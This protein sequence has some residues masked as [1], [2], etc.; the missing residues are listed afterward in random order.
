ML[1]CTLFFVKLL[2]SFN[3]YPHLAADVEVSLFLSL[4]ER[5]M[6]TCSKLEIPHSLWCRG[7][8]N[9]LSIQDFRARPANQLDKAF[10]ILGKPLVSVV[11]NLGIINLRRKVDIQYGDFFL[12]DKI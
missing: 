4:N 9:L 2:E 6:F 5:E 3:A 1:G 11:D 10:H 7:V 12:F 8:G